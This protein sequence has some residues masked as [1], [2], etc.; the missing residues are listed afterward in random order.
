MLNMDDFQHPLSPVH[1]RT[2]AT[3]QTCYYNALYPVNTKV[4]TDS[5]AVARAL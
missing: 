5:A 4:S 1:K 3:T 2:Y